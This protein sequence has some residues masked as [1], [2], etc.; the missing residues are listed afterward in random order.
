MK[1]IKTTFSSFTET[2]TEA[3]NA[4][5]REFFSEFDAHF[6]LSKNDRRQFRADFEAAILLLYKKGVPMSEI[7]SRLAL[8]NLGGFYAR[9]SVLWFPLDDAAKIYPISMDHGSQQVFRISIYFKEDVIPELLQ[10]ALTFTIKRYASFATTLKKGFFWHYLDTVKKRFPIEEEHNLPCQPIKVSSSGSQSFRLMYH[11]N[12]VS[13][14]FFHVLTDGTGAL[15]FFKSLTAEYLRLC[16]IEAPLGDIWDINDTPAREEFENAFVKVEKAKNSSGFVD[17]PAAQM[18]GRMTRRKPCRILHLKMDATKLRE[19]AKSYG[20][21][22]TAYLLMQMFYACSASTD[23]LSGDINI[24]LPINMRK[25]YPS[26]T[27]R[28]FSMY[29]GI[30]IPIEKIGNKEELLA[31]INAQLLQ[32]AEKE[33]MREMIT[34]AVNIVSSIRLIP[35]A[36]KQPIAKMIYGM[37]GE[38]IYTTTFSNLGVVNFPEEFMEH[39]D[40]MDFCLGAQVTNRL[41]CTA[42]TCAGVATFSISKMTLDPAFEEKM[43]QLLLA[44]GIEATVEGSDYYAR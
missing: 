6:L 30:R 9:P 27:V 10:M 14:E 40:S 42:I 19:V 13:A 3:E 7:L 39:I 29:C 43:Y 18:N 24:Q 37:L 38:K 8:S 17:K 28:N 34:A 12:R 11:Q 31:E 23:E 20:A 35:L 5:L 32:K 1:I 41:A 2:L 36:I 4:L 21:T 44:D 22:V 15:T 16:G 25:F 26:K 33:K